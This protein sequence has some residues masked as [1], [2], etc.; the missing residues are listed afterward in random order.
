M[1]K[2]VWSDETREQVRQMF[3][4][5]GLSYGQIAERLGMSRDMVA[6]LVNR[7]K[8][9]GKGRNP[10]HGG[11]G[12]RRTQAGARPFASASPQSLIDLGRTCCAWPIG[13]PKDRDFRFCGTPTDD[14]GPYCIAHRQKAYTAA[15]PRER[16]EK[17]ADM[18]RDRRGS[19]S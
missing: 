18:H 11:H 10:S 9:T 6:G 8:L 15:Q 12:R 5:D 17:P 1:G 14:R 3:T 16:R 2:R 13:D 19:W 4:E 7:L